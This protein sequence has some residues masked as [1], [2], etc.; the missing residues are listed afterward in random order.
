MGYSFKRFVASCQEGSQESPLQ[1]LENMRDER[2]DR[3]QGEWEASDN[4]LK[5]LRYQP[6]NRVKRMRQEGQIG[7]AI[8]GAVLAF[9]AGIGAA[10]NASQFPSY[11]QDCRIEM[12]RLVC[13]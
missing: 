12:N 11:D 4:P 2:L 5:H 10:A 1:C 8:S 7:L 3:L 13:N 6:K 9:I